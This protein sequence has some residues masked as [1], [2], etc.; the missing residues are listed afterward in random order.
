MSE[1]TQLPLASPD[2]VADLL[3]QL[4]AAA[5]QVFSEGRVDFDR[6]RAALGDHIDQ[7]PERYGLNWAGKADAFRNVRAPS[8]GTLLPMP[9]D[10]VNWDQSE[11]LIIEGDNLEV[12]KLLQKSYHGQ[13]KM[14]YIDP[15]YNTGKEFIYPD[16]F[17]EGLSDYLRYSGQV[18][19]EGL[20]RTTNTESSGR[21]HSKWLSMMYPRL[22]LARNLLRD[23]GVI[24]V[25]IDDNEVHNL[26]MLMN[27][28][29]GEENFVVQ[30]IWKSKS[31]G[32]NDSRFVAV[33]HEYILGFA[34][35][36]ASLEFHL[37]RH[38]TVTTNYNLQD[39]NGEYSLDRL[40]KQSLGYI[41]S[42]DFP[43]K[44]P[45]GKTYTVHH[46]DKDNKVARW[47]WGKETVASRHNELVFK[48]GFV[49]TKNYK[50]EGAI[51]RSLLIEDRFGRTRTGKTSLAEIFP[52]A[53][54]DN[55]KPHKLIEFLARI[56][57]DK[58]AIV[59]DF[60]A[61][62]G[63]TA[64][65]L[66]TLN[67]EDDGNRKAILVQLPEPVE[68]LTFPTI[69]HIT[70]ERV[71]RVIARLDKE[72]G[73]KKSTRGFRAFKLS[74]SNFRIWNAERTP[75]DPAKLAEQLQLYADN[76]GQARSE[77]D[78]LYELVLKSGLPLSCKVTPVTVA[79]AGAWSVD[80]NKLLILLNKLVSREVLRAMIA[81]QPQQMLCLDAAFNGDDA[82]KTSI[83]LEARSHGI[84]FR[85]V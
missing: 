57:A 81:L 13:V 38:A 60:F 29:F 75:D 40:D 6:L 79:G 30:F 34:R 50:K 70:R 66:L 72:D 27:E 18:S 67:A 61:G 46:K 43:I 74:S 11:N 62:S 71:R 65:A 58:Q 48:D 7:S 26:R 54:F 44:G 25:S 1:D 42:L 52:R 41:E 33:D 56:A 4:R 22:F 59:L 23:D 84:S 2:P 20:Q 76:S 77:Q 83:V 5:P 78:I 28:V 80:D 32:A 63:T 82:L 9:G 31:G 85:T 3:A 15:P 19:E 51:P 69:A 39:E 73:G 24:F 35:N 17:H 16:N 53:P 45:D 21:Y 14:I 47:R 37:D 55:P 49:Y 68:N 36:A 8:V 12:L 64:H 10:S